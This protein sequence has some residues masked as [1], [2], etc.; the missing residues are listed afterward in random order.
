MTLLDRHIFKGVF[1][2][3]AAAVAL[4]GFVLVVG[5]F[6]RDLLGPVLSGQ[7]A[8][9]TVVRLVLLLVPFVISYAAAGHPDRRP[10]DP[11]RAI[12]N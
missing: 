6:I 8:F 7:L 9:G 1:V 2:T 12:R 10:A 5:N 11:R 4:F 3:C